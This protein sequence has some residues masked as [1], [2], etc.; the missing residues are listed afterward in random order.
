MNQI[1][2]VLLNENAAT[3]TRNKS[4][5]AGLDLYASADIFIP[6][7][8]TRVIPT[9]VAIGVPSGYVGKIEDRSSLASKGLRTGG[10]V[11]DHGYT[12][13]VKV[14]IHNIT[15]V[16]FGEIDLK[17]IENPGYQIKKG[18][19][20]AQLLLYRIET[21]SVILVDSLEESERGIYGFGSSGR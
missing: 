2:V 4:T 3:P 21:P 18:D 17:T 16:D 10:G 14:V 5:D 20:I 12:G 13:E 7:A 8:E 11:V 9:S 19:K 6:F 15:N 1:K